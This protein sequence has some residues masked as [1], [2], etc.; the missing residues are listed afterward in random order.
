MKA[1][2]FTYHIP[3]RRKAYDSVH[4]SNSRYYPPGINRG[5]SCHRKYNSCSNVSA[6]LPSLSIVWSLC[7]F[8]RKVSFLLALLGIIGVSGQGNMYTC[9]LTYILGIDYFTSHSEWQ[10]ANCQIELKIA[11]QQNCRPPTCTFAFDHC[12]VIRVKFP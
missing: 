11:H 9:I 8:G 6:S 3:P 4:I 1:K 7:G 5:G 2:P 10:I 12:E